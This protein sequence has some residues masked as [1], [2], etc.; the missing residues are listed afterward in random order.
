[1]DKQFKSISRHDLSQL[2]KYPWPGNV[3]EL[4]N[5]IERA[6]ITSEEPVLKFDLDDFNTKSSNGFRSQKKSLEE[7]EREHILTIL[8]EC[9]WKINGKDGAAYKLN[10]PPSTLRS[11]MKKLNIL[12]P[13]K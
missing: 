5:M 13:A 8:E 6:I 12:R 7:A 10:L 4:E 2:Q 1:M 3:R 9:K 11:K